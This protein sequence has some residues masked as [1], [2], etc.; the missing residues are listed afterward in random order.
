MPQARR[1]E[2]WWRA[3][4]VYR[5]RRQVVI[6][7][8][9]FSSGLP[10]LLTLSTL[11]YW[12]AKLGVDKTT[13]GLFA[14]VGMPYTWK[15]LWSPMMDRYA[16]PFLGRRR[17]WMLITQLALLVTIGCFG[18]LQPQFSLQGVALLA[19]G[20]AFFSASR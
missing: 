14:L 8:M 7:L 19:F 1:I 9:G 16:P 10:L 17:G 12:L 20:V 11:S 5:D 6:L 3:I 18:W 2:S 4:A 13:I 15:F